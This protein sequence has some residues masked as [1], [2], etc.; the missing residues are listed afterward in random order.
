MRTRLLLTIDLIAYMSPALVGFGY[1][2]YVLTI[3]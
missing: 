1:V 3:Q 2:L